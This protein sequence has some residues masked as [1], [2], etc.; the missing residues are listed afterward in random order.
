VA[1][2][3]NQTFLDAGAATLTGDTLDCTGLENLFVEVQLTNTVALNGT[4]DF[5]AGIENVPTLATV[6]FGTAQTGGTTGGYAYVAANGRLTLTAVGGPNS[7]MT[8]LF[9]NP[10][11]LFRPVFTYGSGGG[12]MRL[13]LVAWGFQVRTTP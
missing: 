7:R 13:R 12:T 5:T 6:A 11:K 8:L 1:V 4:I 10:P 9:A 2:I 3:L